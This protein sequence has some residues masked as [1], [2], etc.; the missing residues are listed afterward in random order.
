[1]MR[2]RSV[3]F[4]LLCLLMMVSACTVETVHAPEKEPP[5]ETAV[6]Q[7][8]HT[9][10]PNTTI[11]FHRTGG[12]AGLDETWRIFADGRISTPAGQEK[13][14]SPEQVAQLVTHLEQAGFF[15][16][17]PAYLP[18]DP[19][20]D[21]FFYEI[22][23]ITP[24]QQHTVRTVDGTPDLPPALTLAIEEISTFITTMDE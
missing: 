17:A 6:P 14:V 5:R 21:R 24:E 11:V 18:D 8:T 16:L 22:T 10:P 7:P 19:C 13:E 15:E 20:C 1:M 23:L 3:W 12:F 9:H 2:F 4:G